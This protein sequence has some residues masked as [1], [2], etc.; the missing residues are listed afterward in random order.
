MAFDLL[1]AVAR[2]AVLVGIVWGLLFLGGLKF[3]SIKVLRKLYAKLILFMI[4]G[5]AR[6]LWAPQVKREGIGTLADPAAQ[7]PRELFGEEEYP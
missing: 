2:V 5:I 7:R 6:W 1:N 4:S 3:N